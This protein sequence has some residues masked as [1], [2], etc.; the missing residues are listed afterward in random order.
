MRGE[1]E[2]E[3]LRERTKAGVAGHKRRET[4][5]LF[6]AINWRKVDEFRAKS[7]LWSAISRVMG[8]PYNTR[9]VA[10]KRCGGDTQDALENGWL[11]ARGR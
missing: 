3:N 7:L 4:G 10:K 8:I 2:R 5:R 9:L 11:K 1:R 6:C